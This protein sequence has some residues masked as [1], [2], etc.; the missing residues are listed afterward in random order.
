MTGASRDFQVF[1]K[2]AGALCNLGCHYCYYLEKEKLY[3]IGG[4]LR[5]PEDVLEAYVV[6]HI[7]AWPDSVVRFSW[8]GG[9]PTLLGLD[10]FRKIVALQRKHATA[11]RRVINGIQTNGTLLNDAWCRFLAA[12]KFAVGISLDGP[13]G[14]HNRYRLKKDGRPTHE[15]AIRG[16][17][18]LQQHRIPCEILCV[19]SACNVQHPLR[20]YRFFRQLE[21]AY[22]TFLPLVE[23]RPGHPK[24]VSDRTVS[25]EAWGQFLCDVFDEW[26]T[27][28][29]GRIKVQ[30]FEEAARPALGLGHTLC[31][32][33]QTCGGVPVVEQNGDFYCCDHFVDV[34]HRLGNICTTPL[35]ELLESSEQRAFGRLKLETLPPYCRACS[36]RAMCN[37]GCPKN[38][39]I[40][41]PDGESGLNFLCAGY[42]Q[43]FTHCGPF[44]EQVSALRRQQHA[45]AVPAP[46][47]EMTFKAGRNDPCP[48]GSGKK[49]KT[50]CKGQ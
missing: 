18:L 11:G 47:A 50:C 29:I 16:Y 36:V 28:D 45:T 14:M 32:F 49:Y 25:A 43:F 26:V 34:A 27:H 3:E 22:L 12:E 33:K 2:P 20:V 31:I 8:H 9:E 42:R 35:V 1:A 38:R 5:M 39:L 46:R 24:G 7:D 21:A 44:L 48:C 40:E 19:V 23:R 4:P 6:Q 10:Y 37:G 41:T 30:I 13:Q 17:R 15:K